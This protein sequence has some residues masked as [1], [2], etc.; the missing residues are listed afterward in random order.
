MAIYRGQQ[1]V[2]RLSYDPPAAVFGEEVT[3]IGP[4]DG[5]KL[6]FADESWLLFRQSGT[7]PVLRIYSEATSLSRV[8]T[9]LDTGSSLPF[10]V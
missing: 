1:F 9:L 2:E 10:E 4:I 6:L 7:E 5:V 8:K 3:G